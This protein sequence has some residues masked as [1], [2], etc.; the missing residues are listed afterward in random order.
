LLKIGAV[1]VP[2]MNVEKSIR[3]YKEILELQHVGTWPGNSGADFYFAEE[4]QYLTLVKVEN[5]QPMEFTA[6]PKYQNPYYNFTI[7]DLKAYHE[8]LQQKGVNVTEIIDQGPIV[9]FDFYDLDG[10]KFGVVVDKENY[11][12]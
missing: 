3:W 1:F 7:N 4:R 10:N 9:G 12:F 8:K 2:V 5:K 6:S 11:N